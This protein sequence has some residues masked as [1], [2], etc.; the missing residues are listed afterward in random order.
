MPLD[1]KDNHSTTSDCPTHFNKTPIVYDDNPASLNGLVEDV[2]SSALRRQGKLPRFERLL[3][4]GTIIVG[5]VVQC[6]DVP[7]AL[8]VA[9][10]RAQPDD[11]VA[12]SMQDRC[13]PGTP[14]RVAAEQAYLRSQNR[15]PIAFTTG[16]GDAVTPTVLSEADSK[17][18]KVFPESI[19]EE[20]RELMY[21][22]LECFRNDA[23]LYEK[24][25]K[26]ARNSG[27]ALITL[28]QAKCAATLSVGHSLA[29]IEYHDHTR[30]C[31]EGE[32]DRESYTEFW[33]TEERLGRCL[34]RPP[35]MLARMQLVHNIMYK[36]GVDAPYY[37]AWEQSTLGGTLTTFELADER[38][39]ALLTSRFLAGR[40]ADAGNGSAP[41][42]RATMQTLVAAEVAKEVALIT[43]GRDPARQQP[44]APRGAR[45]AAAGSSKNA[46]KSFAPSMIP[47]REFAPLCSRAMDSKMMP[48]S[49]G[50]FWFINGSM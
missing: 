46:M 16:T 43:G 32:L 10:H 13:P 40:V 23:H 42:A 50:S 35:E 39:R 49:L 9:H 8:M 31:V 3:T 41:K 2:L 12:Y 37:Q 36:G 28:L 19:D 15:P 33:R 17:T 30:K 20:D 25:A 7:T 5:N 6:P 1:E 27:R 21:Y 45:R 4:T 24:L 14:A 47:R 11:R 34:Q 18:I 48:T 44:A 26:E 38:A 29:D 22:I